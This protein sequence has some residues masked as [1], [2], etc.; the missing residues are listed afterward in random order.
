MGLIQ[1]LTKMGGSVLG[2]K[3]EEEGEGSMVKSNSVPSWIETA[4]QNVFSVIALITVIGTFAQQIRDLWSS[5]GWT[6]K[7]E[8]VLKEPVK[9]E[10]LDKVFK[11]K[12]AGNQNL[13]LLFCVI[14]VSSYL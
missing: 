11:F 1:Q 5:E 2:R 12:L 14:V 6:L 13:F 4:F 8:K 3:G 10:E 9:A 7:R